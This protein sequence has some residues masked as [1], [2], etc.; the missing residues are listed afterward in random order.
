[1][2]LMLVLPEIAAIS[3]VVARIAV[4]ALDRFLGRLVAAKLKHARHI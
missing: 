4:F 2:L 1:M 3:A